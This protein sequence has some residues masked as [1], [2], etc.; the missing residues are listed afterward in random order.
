MSS[1]NLMT[2]WQ[3][4]EPPYGIARHLQRLLFMKTRRDWQVIE[5]VSRYIPTSHL[6][7][8]LPLAFLHGTCRCYLR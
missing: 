4:R 3:V 5:L 7:S 1:C 8:F 2:V 6:V